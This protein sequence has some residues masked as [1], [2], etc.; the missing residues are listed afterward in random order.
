MSW[1]AHND[2]ADALRLV[3]QSGSGSIGQLADALAL[4]AAKSD[5]AACPDDKGNRLETTLTYEPQARFF[6][7]QKAKRD[8]DAENKAKARNAL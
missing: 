1:R 8:K 2:A 6:A 4:S 3:G 5:L 7:E